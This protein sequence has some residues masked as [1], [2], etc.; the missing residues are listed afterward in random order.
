M[1][2]GICID[3]ELQESALGPR[4]GTAELR[5]TQTEGKTSQE[6]GKVTVRSCEVNNSEN[7]HRPRLHLTFDQ[8]E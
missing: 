1:E 5:V 7:L 4:E 6:L 8:P 2:R 3:K